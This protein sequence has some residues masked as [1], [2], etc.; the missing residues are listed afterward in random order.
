MRYE[1]KSDVSLKVDISLSL[2]EKRI[3]LMGTAVSK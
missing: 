2:K 3:N 1:K